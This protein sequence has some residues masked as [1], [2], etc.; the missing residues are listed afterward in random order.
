MP[1]YLKKQA[2]IKAQVKD[3]LF[4]KVFIKLLEKYFNYSIVFSAVNKA[5]LLK[6]FKINDYAIKIKRRKQLFL[7]QFI[8]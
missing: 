2:K 1:V 3:L 7:A 5:K 8:A 4:N 6:H